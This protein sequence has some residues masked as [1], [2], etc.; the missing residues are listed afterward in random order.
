MKNKQRNRLTSFLFGTN[1]KKN[2]DINLDSKTIMKH[3]EQRSLG[4]KFFEN[5]FKKRPSSVPDQLKFTDNNNNNN[6]NIVKI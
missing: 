5:F 1:K 6:L 3:S 2:D 4:R